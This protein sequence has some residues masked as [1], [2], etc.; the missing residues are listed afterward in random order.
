MEKMSKSKFNG[1]DPT[2]II[3]QFG[4]D[5]TRMYILSL[6][7]PEE[8]VV[9]DSVGIIGMQRMLTRVSRLAES[10][11]P[12]V[13]DESIRALENETI[14][15]VSAAFSNSYALH[16]ALADIFKLVN[17][18]QT[19]PDYRAVTSVV[20]MLAP[21][22]PTLCDSI[23]KDAFGNKGVV[24]GAEWPVCQDEVVSG[25]GRM[26]SVSVVVGGRPAGSFD[27]PLEG[28][29]GDRALEYAVEHVEVGKRVV[30][31]RVKQVILK[32]KKHGGYVLVVQ[33]H[34]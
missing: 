18:L 17:A 21:Y 24:D 6:N 9:W 15:K 32:E 30:R 16:T 3:S 29:D 28:I 10:I 8:N 7:A 13:I 26:V 12:A 23:W 34:K 1:V 31:E 2:H 4:S 19:R 14:R 5:V 33:L 22:A 20:R 27:V 11:T 25:D